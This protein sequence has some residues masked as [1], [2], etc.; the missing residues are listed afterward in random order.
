M[1]IT[2][3]GSLN[4]DL[5][6]SVERL[7]KPGETVIGSSIVSAPGGK[8]ANQA[9]AAASLS[10]GVRMIGRVGDDPAAS[11]LIDDLARRGVDISGVLGTPGVLTGAATVAVEPSGENLIIVAPGANTVLSPGDITVDAVRAADVVL[12]QLEV[13]IESVLAAAAH[14]GGLVVLNPAPPAALPAA[15]LERADV[16]VPN[17][18]ELAAL[19]GVVPT[20]PDVASLAAL[21]RTVTR[22]DV[23]VTMG[24]RG[25]LVVPSAGGHLVIEPPTVDVVDTTG[26]GDCFCGALCVALARGDSLVDAARYATAAATLS[27]NGPGAR[28]AL[29]TDADVRAAMT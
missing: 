22:R 27:T 11:V 10:G 6:V 17:E 2:V 19:A 15:L 18:W 20:S 26:A 25:A 24:S 14:A 28:G 7:P 12:L 8:G 16:L 1:S 13:P 5:I 9:A 4:L 21:A 23:V 3:V 29:S